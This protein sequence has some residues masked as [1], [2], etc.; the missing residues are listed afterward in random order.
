MIYVLIFLEF[1]TNYSNIQHHLI[2]P[3][4]LALCSNSPGDS[5]VP[6]TQST[7]NGLFLVHPPVQQSLSLIPQTAPPTL[8]QFVCQSGTEL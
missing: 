5:R 8:L 7:L 1:K 6:A 2:Y 3:K 4:L